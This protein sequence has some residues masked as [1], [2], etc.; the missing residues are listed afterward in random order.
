MAGFH[1][2]QEETRGKQ[3]RYKFHALTLSAGKPL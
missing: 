3:T 1:V 2:R